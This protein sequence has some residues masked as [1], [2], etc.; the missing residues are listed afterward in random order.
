VLSS[1]G[2]KAGEQKFLKE[3]ISVILK[4]LPVIKPEEK[5]IRNRYSLNGHMLI[6][7][8]CLLLF[9]LL[10]NFCGCTEPQ[11]NTNQ[12]G[13]PVYEDIP[14][15]QDYAVKFYAGSEAGILKKC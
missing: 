1:P 15:I 8:A 9:A 12:S 7:S 3:L 14:Y 13:Q 4:L 10:I 11:E 2:L 6:K 5:R